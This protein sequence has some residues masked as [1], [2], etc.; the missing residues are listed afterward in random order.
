[1]YNSG[2]G[3]TAIYP[4]LATSTHPN[5]T[6]YCTEIDRKSFDYATKNIFLNKLTS[7]IHAQFTESNTE[8]LIPRD[9]LPNKVDFT[10]CNP[11]FY[12]SA[13]DFAMSQ[14]SK[15]AK[16]SAVCTGAETEMICPD[17]DIGFV[18]RILDESLVLRDRIQWYTSMFGKLSS[19]YKLVAKLKEASITNWAVT[20]L[21]KTGRTQRWVVGWSFG[22]R[23]P[24]WQVCGDGDVPNA[25]RPHPTAHIVQT[26]PLDRADLVRLLDTCLVPLAPHGLDWTWDGETNIGRGSSKS[27]AWSPRLLRKR[28][29]AQM[30]AESAPG[31]DI[32]GTV[33]IPNVDAPVILG[34]Q[35]SICMSNGEPVH[36]EI[37]W[38]RGSDA[39]IYNSLCAMFRNKI[40]AAGKEKDRAKS[41]A[42][43]GASSPSE[44]RI[45]LERRMKEK[46][47]S[48]IN[49]S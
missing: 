2:T 43:L 27:V 36:L 24:S 47:D 29:R 44:Q 37:C 31:D 7:R 34:F 23:R 26:Y 32:P 20:V 9:A 42:K 8:P 6:M 15:A 48:T 40:K 12:S 5:W 49:A 4:L 11:P 19:V 17:G 33:V 46:E 45:K 38:L 35:I 30:E 1:M 25:L 41:K 13:E 16:P 3:A 22:D 28:N 10:M 14:A 21:N 39:V 18:L